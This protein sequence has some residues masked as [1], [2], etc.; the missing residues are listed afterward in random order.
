MYIAR[1]ADVVVT[2][3]GEVTLVELLDVLSGRVVKPMEQVAGLCLPG[4]HGVRRTSRRESIRDLDALPMPAWDL[5][6]VGRYQALWRHAHGFHS[7]NLVTTRGCPYHC[8]W[9]AKPIYGQRYTTR[10]PENVVDEILWLKR[11]YRPDHLSIADDIFGLKPGWLEQFRRLWFSNG[12]PRSFAPAAG[13]PGDAARLPGRSSPHVAAW[14]MGAESD[15]SACSTRWRRRIR[16]RPD[17]AGYG[18]AA[19][20][21][22]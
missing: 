3:E 18:G 11:T 14:W 20:C 19:G 7:M 16:A 2:G 1:G 10:S 8:N 22:H 9:C 15:R 5:V 12:M 17:S 6:D 4:T 21:G 13:R